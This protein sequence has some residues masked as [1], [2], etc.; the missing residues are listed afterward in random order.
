MAKGTTYSRRQRR[1]AYRRAGFLRIKNGY[2]TLGPIARAWYQKTA[3]EGKRLQE[4]HQNMVQEQIEEKL[5]SIL[6]KSKET[7]IEL[8]YNEAEMAMLEEAYALRAVKNKDTFRADRKEA[9][10]LEKEAYQSKISRA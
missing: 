8:G 6:N 3:E 2:N 4:A 1:E 9:K 5:Q 10:R 7:W